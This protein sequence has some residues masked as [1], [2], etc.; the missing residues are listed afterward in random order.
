[1]QCNGENIVTIFGEKEDEIL[2][3]YFIFD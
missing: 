1:M 3:T 2:K